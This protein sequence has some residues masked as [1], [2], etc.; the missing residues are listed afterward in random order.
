M[1]RRKT[2]N[3]FTPEPGAPPP[4]RAR[5]RRFARFEE[6]DALGIV[7]HGR[8]PSYFEDGR[9]AFGEKY[10]MRYLDMLREGFVA[11]IV[12][13][14]IDYHHPL[15]LDEPFDIEAAMH[16]CDAARL[17]SSYVITGPGN[18]LVASGYTVQMLMN[19]DREVLVTWPVWLEEFRLKWKNGELPD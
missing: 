18:R 3:Y 11:P 15:R 7:W 13:M 9:V 4:L 2:Q 17:N 8:Y 1:T 10:N 12:Q 6:V 5:A 19:L 16:Y 14:H